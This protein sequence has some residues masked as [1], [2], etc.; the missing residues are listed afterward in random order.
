VVEQ[1]NSKDVINKPFQEGK[2]VGEFGADAAF[3]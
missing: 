3:R 2:A 1:L